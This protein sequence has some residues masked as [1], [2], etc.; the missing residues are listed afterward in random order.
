MAKY[1]IKKE[2][3]GDH[4]S[5]FAYKI[6]GWWIF[7]IES[8]VRNCCSIHSANDCEERLK[9]AINKSFEPKIVKELEL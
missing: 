2:W 3:Q 9:K 8:I 1:V 4:Y 5:W 7:K 6:T